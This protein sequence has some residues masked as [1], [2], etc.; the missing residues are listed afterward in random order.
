MNQLA[1]DI[2]C[3]DQGCWSFGL[4]IGP[5][6]G[7]LLA[8]PAT[9][10]PNVFSESGL[11]GRFVDEVASFFGLNALC[12]EIV[13]IRTVLSV[14]PQDC[15]RP[16]GYSGANGVEEIPAEIQDYFGA[17]FEYSKGVL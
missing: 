15:E 7:G 2:F 10:Y 9:H 4:V 12:C 14:V 5:A 6:F 11:F 13:S 16:P 3:F 17:K 8:Q 1:G